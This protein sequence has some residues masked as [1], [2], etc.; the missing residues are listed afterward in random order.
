MKV[1]NSSINFSSFTDVLLHEYMKENEIY[2][3]EFVSRKKS[4]TTE[5]FMNEIFAAYTE[6]E[7]GC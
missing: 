6:P 5:E 4:P 3:S 7:N 2:Q 1:M